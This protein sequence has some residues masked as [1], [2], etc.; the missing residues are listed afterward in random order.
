MLLDCKRIHRQL[1]GLENAD[2][3]HIELADIAVSSAAVAN[4]IVL[5]PDHRPIGRMA[6]A[7]LLRALVALERRL[8]ELD[9]EAA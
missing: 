9:Q 5:A 6:Q 7:Q 3:V 4:A 2:L 1:H 8:A